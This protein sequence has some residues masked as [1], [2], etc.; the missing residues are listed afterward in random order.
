MRKTLICGERK[1]HQFN[2]TSDKINLQRFDPSLVRLL[3]ESVLCAL[4]EIRFR[5]DCN[6]GFCGEAGAS[7]LQ[8]YVTSFSTN[9]MN[10]VFICT[11]NVSP[12]ASTAKNATGLIPAVPIATYNGLPPVMSMPAGRDGSRDASRLDSDPNSTQHV[13][14]QAILPIT[15][16]H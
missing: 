2:A 14:N 10:E 4:R 7:C 15:Y 9:D 1:T 5:F 16:M 11:C 8:I 13:I 3:A 12:P 6:H